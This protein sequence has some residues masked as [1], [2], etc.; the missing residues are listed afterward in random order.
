MLD[1]VFIM[2]PTASGK[3]ALALKLARELNGEIISADSMQ[4]YRSLEIGTAQPDQEERCSV[5]HHLVG[6]MDIS[7]RAD[8]FSF[9]QQAESCIFEIRSRGHL[10]IVCGGT[11]MYLKALLYGMD[12]LPGDRTLRK[13][14]DEKY[15]SPA[16]ETALHQKMSQLDPQALEK[17]K[18]CRRRLI[19]AMEVRLLTGKSI[20]E[21]QTNSQN[22]LRYPNIKAWKLDPPTDILKEKIA[23]R[24][25]LML[26]N[27]WIKEAENAI[28]RGLFDTPTAHQA[29][30]YRLIGR[31][32]DGE[33][34]L[35]TLEQLI[36]TATWQYA[37]RQRTWF[38]HQ[39]PESV[40]LTEY[41]TDIIPDLI[42]QIRTYGSSK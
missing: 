17:W 2:G 21:I 11:G 35:E 41:G 18:N 20:L 24:T 8:V 30:G 32:L 39:H 9:R 3:S 4:L 5:P 22:S 14:L 40:S 36:I 26:K 15:D 19:R 25:R 27:G 28:V 12:D 34:N 33:Y 7:E 29:L 10:P 6:I 13:D 16:G 37:R 42:H 31:Y 1:A 38:R 23:V